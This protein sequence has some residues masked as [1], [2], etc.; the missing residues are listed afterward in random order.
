MTLP[1]K[2]LQD[3]GYATTLPTSTLVT[4]VTISPDNVLFSI[5]QS[6]DTVDVFDFRYIRL[7]DPLYH[8]MHDA[9]ADVPNG[10]YGVTCMQ[11]YTNYHRGPNILLSGGGDG[12][13]RLWDL[14]RSSEDTGKAICEMSSGIGY[15][16]CG[17]I[18]RDELPLIVGDCDGRILEFREPIYIT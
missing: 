1:P 7:S 4:N 10:Y 8:C 17:D 13:V 3:T 15:F 6:D 11:W 5:S 12:A 16:H 2:L 18:Y 9:S 14:R